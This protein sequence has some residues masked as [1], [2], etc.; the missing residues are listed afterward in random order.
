[1]ITNCVN[2]WCKYHNEFYCTENCG[3]FIRQ[4]TKIKEYNFKTNGK[5]AIFQDHKNLFTGNVEDIVKK[6]PE[7]IIKSANYDWNTLCLTI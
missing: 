6:Y 7:N 5:V 3:C 2:T 4:N 1:M